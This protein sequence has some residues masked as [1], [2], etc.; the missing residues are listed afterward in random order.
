MA[1]N[2]NMIIKRIKYRLRNAHYTLMY[3]DSPP[4]SVAGGVF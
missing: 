3:L 4:L 1:D 2:D